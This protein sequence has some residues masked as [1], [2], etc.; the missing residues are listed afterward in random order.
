MYLWVRHKFESQQPI[1]RQLPLVSPGIL[2]DRFHY[3]GSC[4]FPAGEGPVRPFEISED[5]RNKLAGLI[6]AKPGFWGSISGKT[7][8]AIARQLEEVAAADELGAVPVLA[9]LLTAKKPVA[10]AA[11]TAIRQIVAG[12]SPEELRRLDEMNRRFP[13]Y[14]SWPWAQIEPDQLSSIAAHDDVLILGL[15]SFHPSGWVRSEAIKRLNWLSSGDELTFLILRANDWVKPVRDLAWRMIRRRLVPEYAAAFAGN[16]GVVVALETKTRTS[17]DGLLADVY[18]FLLTDPGALDTAIGHDDFRVRRGAFRIAYRHDEERR[19]GFIKRALRDA[20]SLTRLVAARQAAMLS[21]DSL[22]YEFMQIMLS[23]RWHAIRTQALRMAVKDSGDATK[24][25]LIGLLLDRSR[26]VRSAARY[27]LRQFGMED[28]R[29]I[30]LDALG[31]EKEAVAIAGIGECGVADDA[32]AIEPYLGSSRPKILSAAVTAMSR[33]IPDELD[34]MLLDNLAHP[35]KAPSIAAAW[36]LRDRI[37]PL[38][39]PRVVQIYED[40][41]LPFH[42]RFNALKL[43][44]AAGKWDSMIYWLRGSADKEP[45][46]AEYC[47]RALRR[48]QQA[49]NRSFTEPSAPQI[50][51]IRDLMAQ[52]SF[53]RQPIAPFLSSVM[54]SF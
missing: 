41:S 29:S 42:A 54:R 19:V 32:K 30:Y 17:M 7:D 34:N 12:R 18:H 27:Y 8:N 9:N 11:R 22:R 38:T 4:V 51:E 39:E 25:I 13:A 53:A 23:D 36:Q 20:D 10:T 16:M 43:L 37:S 50:Q 21:Q 2:D 26:T 49:Y 45:R 24:A 1:Q 6:Q 52:P 44:G 35:H 40:L 5:T 28:F 31:G 46:I 14:G 48:W 15:L 3:R 33:L 47:E